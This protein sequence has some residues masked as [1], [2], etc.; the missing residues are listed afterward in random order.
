MNP[1]EMMKLAKKMQAQMEE[2]TE[3]LNKQDFVVQK[4]GIEVVFNGARQ[5]KTIKIDDA[6]VDP[7]DTE[8]LETMIII[9]INEALENIEK[10][11]D[12]IESS[13]KSLPI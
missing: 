6:L 3:K 7:D 2:Q 12:E 10:A 4:Q 5:L 11:H 8:T 9:A 1:N 13:M